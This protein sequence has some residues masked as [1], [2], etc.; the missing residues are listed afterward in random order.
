MHTTLFQLLAILRTAPA[1]A[2]TLLAR[3]DTLTSGKPPSLPAFYRHVRRG[4]EEG[5]IVVDG[6]DQADEGPG[7]PRQVYR[8][9]ASGE[10]A[11]TGYARE[12]EVFTTL[13]LQGKV[14]G[15]R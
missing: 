2:S 7:R 5:W 8:I 9:T 3:L 10:S 4:T 13:A 11:L 15:G 14:P 1:D 12:M 6:M